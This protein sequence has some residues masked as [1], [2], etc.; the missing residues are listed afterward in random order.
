MITA[1]NSTAYRSGSLWWRLRVI[2]QCYL[3]S[4]KKGIVL[5]KVS[6]AHGRF[7]SELFHEDLTRWNEAE[8]RERAGKTNL[9]KIGYSS[10]NVGI[11]SLLFYSAAWRQILIC[12]TYKQHDQGYCRLFSQNRTMGLYCMYQMLLPICFAPLKH[13]AKLLHICLEN[14]LPNFLIDTLSLAA[15]FVQ[16]VK[17]L[18][19]SMWSQ[20]KLSKTQK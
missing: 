10:A 16:K 12:G 8:T 18:S 4:T 2:Y 9:L 14:S 5:A 15:T 11:H 20:T 13:R 7:Q 17:L 6:R 1:G 19:S 3:L